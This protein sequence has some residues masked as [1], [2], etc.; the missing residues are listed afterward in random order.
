MD[1]DA[2]FDGCE[3][4]DFGSDDD[5]FFRFDKEQGT[6]FASDSERLVLFAPDAFEEF[7]VDAVRGGDENRTFFFSDNVFSRAGLPASPRVAEASAD[8]SLVA[9]AASFDADLLV[10][11]ITCFFFLL[12]A[13]AELVTADDAPSDGEAAAPPQL[14]ASHGLAFAPSFATTFA[15]ARVAL[16]VFSTFFFSFFGIVCTYL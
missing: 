14:T 16:P 13:V 15:S 5:F 12:A 7:D 6:A 10:A 2:L 9:P 4:V 11:L 1:F 3:V 8:F